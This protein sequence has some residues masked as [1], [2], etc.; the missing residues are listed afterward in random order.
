[1]ETDNQWGNWLTQVDL[2][3]VCVH[4]AVVMM[5]LSIMSYVTQHV[6]CAQRVKISG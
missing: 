2:E 5:L 4:C 6:T 3:N 1:M